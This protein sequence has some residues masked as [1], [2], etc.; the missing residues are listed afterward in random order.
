MSAPA[1]AAL[2]FTIC[3]IFQR[4]IQF[5]VVPIYTRVLNPD[6]YGTYSVFM[7]WTE[8]IQIFCTL[9]MFYNSYN[10]G[11]TKFEK[12]KDKFS[13][14]L[15]GLC[16]V[17]TVVMAAI[18]GVFYQQFDM[19]FGMSTICSILMFVHMIVKSP[20][21]FWMARERYEYRYKVVL[22]G[23]VILS[24]LTPV[25][26]LISLPFFEDKSYAVIISK[27]VIETL[28]G[29]PAVIVIVKKSTALFNR[30]Y[31]KY[32]L[33]NN[34]RLVSY[35][36]SQII[37]NH[38]DRL[39]INNLCDT[40]KAGIYSVAYSAAMLL[41]VINTAVNN[42]VIPWKFKKL[43]NNDTSGIHSVTFSLMAV[44]MVMNA[45]L[46]ALAP[47]AMMI[48]A[49]SEYQE[50][51]WI[52][53][54]VACSA[55]LIFASQQFINVE[56]YFEENHFASMSSI[57]V[58][59]LNVILNYLCISYFGYIAAG[60]TT[61]FCYIVFFIFHY[62]AMRR[63]CKKYMDDVKIWNLKSVILLTVALLLFS[64]VMLICYN[65]FIVRY[66]IVLVVLIIA[67]IKRKAI[68]KV[69]K[70]NK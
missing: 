17:V 15:V 1:K 25:L 67:V 10:V 69:I 62:F 37:L 20:Y 53:P 47:E 31:W 26:A 55:Y 18:Y 23:T 24:V 50:A 8:I 21:L 3:S 45:M 38:S 34:I 22:I 56:F 48:M 42:S 13:A 28:L 35:Y 59:V 32:G 27:I 30:F 5:I 66:I 41:T 12:D 49:S 40:A 7:S 68:I 9:N 6:E 44:V 51:I 19:F 63:V 39:M 33:K 65:G 61:L 54:P 57:A 60:Y 70:F 46:I 4:G 2:W 29:I 16:T 52:I 58:A 64:A 11:L 14:S 36:L 43:K